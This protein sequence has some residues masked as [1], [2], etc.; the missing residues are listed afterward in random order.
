MGFMEKSILQFE[1]TV[2]MKESKVKAWFEENKDKICAEARC[3]GWYAFGFGLA[4]FVNGKLTEYQC[5]LGAANLHEKGLMKFCDPTNG[6]EITLD[7]MEVIFVKTKEILTTIGT[8]VVVGAAS[9]AG[10]AL[11]TNVLDRKF[12]LARA[13]LTQ[14]KSDKIIVVDFKKAK[15]NLGR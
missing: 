5:A 2:D 14:S 3:I 7:K 13:K 10:A 11:W 9:T 15:R 1:R 4:W 12:R 8:L 6:M